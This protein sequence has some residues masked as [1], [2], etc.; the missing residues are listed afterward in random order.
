MGRYWGVSLGLGAVTWAVQKLWAQLCAERHKKG[1]KI[2]KK[3][4]RKK[5]KESIL[6]VIKPFLSA[7]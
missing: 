3:K 2:I 5:E 7:T 4:E 6:M 1:K